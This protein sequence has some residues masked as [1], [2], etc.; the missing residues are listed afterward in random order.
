VIDLRPV[1]R[2]EAKDDLDGFDCGVPALD[3]WLKQFA[4]SGQRAGASVTY[5][6]E[7]GAQIVG[8][9]TLAPWHPTRLNLKH[10]RGG[11]APGCL[12]E[13]RYP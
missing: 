7:Q 8:F 13:G 4:L 1:R 3:E 11:W 5:V 12:A 10:Y 9:Y 2:V 6:L